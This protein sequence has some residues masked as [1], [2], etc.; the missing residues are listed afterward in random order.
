[1]ATRTFDS[2]TACPWCGSAADH[3]LAI[4]AGRGPTEGDALMCA[5][6]G[7]W[8]VLD[9]A[10]RLRR[11]TGKRRWQLALDPRNRCARRA[12]AA[13]QRERRRAP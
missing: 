9:A 11:M 3:A 7:E 1:M 13:L 2:A 4:G 5:E 8:A 6:C 12:W 10:G